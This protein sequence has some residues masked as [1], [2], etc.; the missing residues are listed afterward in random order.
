MSGP[1]I[2]DH[3]AIGQWLDAFEMKTEGRVTRTWEVRTRDHKVLGW[4][5]WYS[6]WR[7]YALVSAASSIYEPEDRWV[8]ISDS[9]AAHFE[10]HGDCTGD[11][12]LSDRCSRLLRAWQRHV[13]T[14]P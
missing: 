11:G 13:N 1:Y 3:E 14:A 2:G 8:N 12:L 6:P 4:V 7:R 5:R 9:F 10:G